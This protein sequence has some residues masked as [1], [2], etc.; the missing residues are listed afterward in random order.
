[1]NFPVKIE[2]L[3]IDLLLYSISIEK[4]NKLAVN[5][6]LY[7]EKKVS[8]ALLYIYSLNALIIIHGLKRVKRKIWSNIK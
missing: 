4:G 7:F 3:S 2:Q 6:S 5:L 8:M 1:V